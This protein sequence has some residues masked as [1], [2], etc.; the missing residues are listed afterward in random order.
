MYLLCL[1]TCYCSALKVIHLPALTVNP[2]PHDNGADDG[3]DDDDDDDENDDDD[4]S[5]TSIRI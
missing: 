4:P 2:R 3:D 1:C 5:K